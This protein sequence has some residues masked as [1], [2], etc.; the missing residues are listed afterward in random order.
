MRK[1]GSEVIV[2]IALFTAFVIFVS[3]YLYFKNVAFKTD[4]YIVTIKFRDVTGLEQSDFVS[5]AGLRIGRVQKLRFDNLSVLVD[6]RIDPGIEIPVDSRAH[7]KSLGMV[8][9]KFIDIIPG[10]SD[11]M[12]QDGETIEGENSGD[13]SDLS[14]SMETLFQQAQELINELRTVLH[15]VMDTDTQQHLK[16]TVFHMRNISSD[17]DNN[18]AHIDKILVNLDSISENMNGILTERRDKVESSIDNFHRASTRFD[19]MTNKLDTSLTSVQTLLTKIENQEGAVGK[20]IYSDE[21][22]NDI[23]HLTAQLDTLVQD[24]KKRPQKYLN[25][26]FIKVF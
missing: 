17:L 21:L 8:G 16:E 26:G 12:L 23:R 13:L 6:V 20:V 1:V 11:Q 24:L 7:I 19:D 22:Y 18:S 25:M 15:T 10:S 5:V 14:G 4:R 3:G 2:G 9:E